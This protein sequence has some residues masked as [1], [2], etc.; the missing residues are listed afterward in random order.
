[1]L[2]NGALQPELKG[3]HFAVIVG[4]NAGADRFLYVDPWAGGSSL[5][6]T[7]GVPG[8]TPPGTK[9]GFL[10][11]FGVEYGPRGPVIRQTPDS[12]GTFQGE[13]SLEVIA[14]PF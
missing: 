3:G 10:G 11:M 9:C 1:M 6:Y 8:L 5:E 7:G 4:C 13:T 12:A 14:G 2:A